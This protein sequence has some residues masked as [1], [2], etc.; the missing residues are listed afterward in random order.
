M[1]SEQLCVLRDNRQYKKTKKLK[2]N[3]K[4]SR[5]VVTDPY[6]SV[7]DI[8]IDG[9]SW[10]QLDLIRKIIIWMGKRYFISREI[11]EFRNAVI[12]RILDS[13]LGYD[14]DIDTFIRPKM[15]WI[16]TKSKKIEYLKRLT[17]EFVTD[18]ENESLFFNIAKITDENEKKRFM[19]ELIEKINHVFNN[20]I[21]DIMK[22][23]ILSSEMDY[24]LFIRINEQFVTEHLKKQQLEGN[25]TVDL[26]YAEGR[27]N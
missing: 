3:W 9:K 1:T 20:K 6:F 24:I 18:S 4:Y 21:A 2:Y 19:D 8:H 27:R 15:K 7:L 10:N 14:F 25:L 22:K 5:E 16:E 17:I 23:I 12:E 26:I 13:S 11:C